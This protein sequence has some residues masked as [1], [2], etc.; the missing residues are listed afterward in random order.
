MLMN[1]VIELRGLKL[2]SFLRLDAMSLT[3]GLTGYLNSTADINFHLKWKM[4]N[5]YEY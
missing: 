3:S 5:L 1:F 2:H 4:K